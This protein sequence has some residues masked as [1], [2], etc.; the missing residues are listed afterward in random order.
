MPIHVGKL[1]ALL[2][3]ND[4]RHFWLLFF[5]A[6]PLAVLD[7]ASV[8]LIMPFMAVT[9]NPDVIT[10]ND[11][12]VNLLSLLGLNSKDEFLYFFGFLLLAIVAISTSAKAFLT[13]FQ[14]QFVLTREYSIGRRLVVAYLNKP[15]EWFLSK[16]SSELGQKILSDANNVV[17]GA[18][19][20]LLL[21]AVHLAITLAMLS[22]MIVVDPV[23]MAT[24]FLTVAILYA[25]I[26]IM[27]HRR[28]RSTSEERNSSNAMR[29][30]TVSETFSAVKEVKI[31]RLEE[32]FISIFDFYAQI[33]SKN[34]AIA[35]TI[36]QLPRYFLEFLAFS[37][38]I[39]VAI[40]MLAEGSGIVDAFPKISLFAFAGYRLLPAIQGTYASVTQLR[41]TSRQI[42]NLY[43]D[44]KDLEGSQESLRPNISTMRFARID[45]DDIFY[46]YPESEIDVLQGVSM[47]VRRGQII[48]FAGSSGSGK[49]TLVDVL[50]GLLTP[51][52]GRVDAHFL[53][54]ETALNCDALHIGYVS[55]KVF[56][57]NDTLKKNIAFGMPDSMIDD[58]RVRDC[59]RISQLD[60]LIADLPEGLDTIIGEGGNALSGGQQQRVAVAR[61][62]YRTPDLLVLDEATSALDNIT[63]E[64]LMTAL[65]A[66][67]TSISAFIIAHRLE[68]LR[69][70]DI[71]YVVEDGRIVDSGTYDVLM[72]NNGFFKSF[73][74]EKTVSMGQ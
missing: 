2:E 4:R 43:A 29:F 34:M 10:S 57:S 32:S 50:C 68:T 62:L 17:T 49:S 40:T 46:R 3:P 45:L 16:N 33:Y 11:F 66:Y 19:Y 25:L 44:L 12:L 63:E 58:R 15:Y 42:E 9:A 70:C 47:S 56:I 37:A 61:A 39:I 18:L 52:S 23:L 54:G 73:L 41:F 7:L 30:S 48:G 28:L 36:I 13:Y 31:N 53:N 1:L 65:T 6:L 38:L 60:D 64:R 59:A 22:L 26:Y 55:Q 69:R 20:F 71:I 51:T 27:N 8:A 74:E 5:L 21:L 14:L 67:M 72:N 24:I 35:Q